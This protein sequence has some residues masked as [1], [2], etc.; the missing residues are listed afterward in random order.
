MPFPQ[1]VTGMLLPK[2]AA[3][4]LEVADGVALGVGD[5]DDDPHTTAQAACVWCA[6]PW[7]AQ[8]FAS[9]V[10]RSAVS[11]KHCGTV[12]PGARTQ[13]HTSLTQY[14]RSGVRLSDGETL[15]VTDGVIEGVTDGVSLGVTDGVTLGVSL[16]L[17]EVDVDGDALGD[18]DADG[19]GEVDSL[20]E[21]DAL[22]EA[23]GENDGCGIRQHASENANSGKPR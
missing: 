12:A 16:V 1:Q 8:P 17:G 22:G 11:C 18:T 21:V 6:G 14:Q 5:A 7:I 4:A 13:N 19:D 20:G 2:L 15:G 9:F 23:L 10:M 3:D